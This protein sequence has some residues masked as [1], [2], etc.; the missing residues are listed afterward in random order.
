MED[1]SRGG[2]RDRIAPGQLVQRR[3]RRNAALVGTV[4]EVLV[5]GRSR[6]DAEVLRGNTRGSRP[7]VPPDSRSGELVLVEVTRTTSQTL[8][9]RPLVRHGHLTGWRT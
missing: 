8:G 9:S 1:R 6:T 4:Q 7:P 2:Q 5:Q 3:C